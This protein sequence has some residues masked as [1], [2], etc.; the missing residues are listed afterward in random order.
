MNEL[1][2]DASQM[3][4]EQ[5][6]ACLRGHGDMP[7]L[8]HDNLAE[9]IEGSKLLVKKFGE[10]NFL[11]KIGFDFDDPRPDAVVMHILAISQLAR[12]SRWDRAEG[13]PP[14]DIIEQ[15]LRIQEG[16]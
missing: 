7:V 2:L 5:L 15:Y 4:A 14:R 11:W 6:E 1:E 9:F 12:D 3:R 10:V 16:R 13:D 8:S